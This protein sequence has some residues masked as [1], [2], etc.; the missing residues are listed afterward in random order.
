MREGNITDSCFG[1]SLWFQKRPPEQEGR[2]AGDAA[3]VGEDRAG[4]L[5]GVCKGN[6]QELLTGWLPR[7]CR[8]TRPWGGDL[9]AWFS[10]H[11]TFRAS[12][13]VLLGCGG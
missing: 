12:D 8:K 6:H 5:S 11:R 1:L 7:G 9:G 13:T 2:M 4:G 3:W 10:A